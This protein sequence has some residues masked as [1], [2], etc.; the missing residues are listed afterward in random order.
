[1]GFGLM[2]DNKIQIKDDIYHVLSCI[3]SSDRSSRK[4]IFIYRSSRKLIFIVGATGGMTLKNVLDL[5][6]TYQA[7][8]TVTLKQSAWLGPLVTWRAS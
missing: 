1:M 3:L 2:L 7:K 5:S 6:V 8:R 4:L